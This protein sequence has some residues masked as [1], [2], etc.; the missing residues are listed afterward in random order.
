[1]TTSAT[2]SRTVTV[3]LPDYA[4]QT[5]TF[6]LLSTVAIAAGAG[7]IFPG[8]AYT[9][10]LDGSGTG[11][12]ALPCPDNDGTNAWHWRVELPDNEMPHFDLAYNAASVSLATLLAAAATTTTA[13]DILD[14]FV[15]LTGDTM[16]GQLN[17]DGTDHAGIKLLSLTTTER[18]ALTPAEGMIIYNETTSQV[19]TYQGGQ[20]VSVGEASAPNADGVGF[21]PAGNI[22][23]ENVQ[24]AIEELDSEK[25]DISHDHDGD[26]DA[27]GAA[28][29]VQGNL[30]THEG[31]SNNPHSVTAAQA[32]AVP[33]DAAILSKTGAYELAS[34]DEAKIIECNGTFTITCPNGLDTGFQVVI[35]NVGSGTIT[36][37]ASTT[38]QS[39]DSANTIAS[40]YAAAL[41]YHRGSNI[42]LLAGDIE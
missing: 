19:Q 6:R 27:L 34:G 26:Y 42:W 25:S 41:V 36:I 1:M 18:D 12:T 4:S 17:F 3:D 24:D 31:D 2:Y 39:K 10:A 37:A 16:T 22:E 21:T 30:D 23:A 35:V 7:E 14:T 29:T 20:W 9:L 15:E 8:K 13:S 11:S 28:E 32:D 40:Q 5:I 38:L 33:E